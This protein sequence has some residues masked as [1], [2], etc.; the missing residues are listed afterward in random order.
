MCGKVDMIHLISK[1]VFEG[2][3][4]LVYPKRCPVCEK[5]IGQ[6]YIRVCPECQE[7]LVYCEEPLCMRCGRMIWSCHSEYCEE[8]LGKQYEFERGFSLFR[9]DTLVKRMIAE[10]KFK[11]RAWYADFFAEELVK[12]YGS[13]LQGLKADLLIPVP[14]HKSRLKTRGFNQAQLVAE[15][16]SELIEIKSANLLLRKGRTKPQKELGF[17]ER[18]K[19]LSGAF[20]IDKSKLKEFADRG[21]L[22]KTVILVDDIYTT[23]ATLNECAGTL[24]AAGIKNIYFLSLSIGRI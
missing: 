7:E 23:G 6:G 2:L 15:K 14:I 4:E 8:C 11:G 19:N 13:T 1:V 21:I 5:A 10:F 22:L 9:Y 20:E 18:K 3:G 24:K 17:E 16:V 12:R